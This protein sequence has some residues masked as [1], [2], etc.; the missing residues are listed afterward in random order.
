[1]QMNA[2]ERYKHLNDKKWKKYEIQ[3][4]MDDIEWQENWNH[5]ENAKQNWRQVKLYCLNMKYRP[6]DTTRMQPTCGWMA[7]SW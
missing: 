5:F 6:K 2:G 4:K 3:M 7:Y 1:M